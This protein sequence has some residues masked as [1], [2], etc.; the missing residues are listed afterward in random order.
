[1][2]VNKSIYQIKQDMI[3]NMNFAV[4]FG[5]ITVLNCFGNDQCLGLKLVSDEVIQV[6]HCC[7]NSCGFSLLSLYPATIVT[8]F[9][10]FGLYC[11]TVSNRS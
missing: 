9:R 7:S 2:R 5:V 10:R 3:M 1:M 4:Y 11:K 6:F 8:V